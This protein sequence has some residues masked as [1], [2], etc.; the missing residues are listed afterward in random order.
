M[1]IICPDCRRQ[2]D[3]TLFQFGRTIH[4]TC[5]RRV[6]LE[7]RLSISDSGRAPRFMADAMLGRLARWLRTLGYDT[8]FDPAITDEELVRRGLQERRHILTR[9]RRLFREW[10]VAGTLLESQKPL[11]Q[12]REVIRRFGL[13]RP[14]RLF[15]RCRECNDELDPV[16][17]DALEGE[18]PDGVARRIRRLEGDPEPGTGTRLARCPGCGRIYWE[19]THTERMRAVV[20]AAFEES[21]GRRTEGGWSMNP[22]RDR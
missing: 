13:Q 21:G 14:R 22:G 5:G 2:Y 20:D 12:L 4:C 6:G 16:T 11:T 9:D 10:R 15:T 19:G 1:A 3:V 18:I 7:H 8:A 17:L